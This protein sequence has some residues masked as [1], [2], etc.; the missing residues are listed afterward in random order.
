MTYR[1]SYSMFLK[2]SSLFWYSCA[3]RRSWYMNACWLY[4]VSEML[5]ILTWYI[6]RS[7][8]LIASLA[9]HFPYLILELRECI[10]C[11]ALDKD[12]SS[13]CCMPLW[14]AT[15]NLTSLVSSLSYSALVLVSVCSCFF[16]SDER[17]WSSLHTS[18]HDACLK[19]KAT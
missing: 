8:L 13:C 10:A 4:V 6:G 11:R 19:N 18:Y 3:Y 9:I 1:R 5:S 17:W 14:R 2:S 7:L 16:L 15:S 12:S